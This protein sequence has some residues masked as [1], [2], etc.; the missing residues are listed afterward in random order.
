MDV[1]LL[2]IPIGIVMLY[3]G[4]EWLVKG[5][6]SLALKLR[7]AP[8]VVGLTV[9]AFGSSAPEMV[10]SIV[11]SNNPSIILGN[12]IGS[13]IANIGI[14]IGLAALICP[15]VA[16][17]DSMRI[18]IM[19]MVVMSFVMLLMMV[20]DGVTLVEGIV[21]F[22]ILFSFIFM[23]YRM[24]K[25]DEEGQK[26]YVA[27]LDEGEVR[28]KWNSYPVLIVLIIIGLALLYFGARFF[29]EGSV[30]LAIMFDVSE[31]VIGLLVVALGTSL[32]EICICLVAAKRGENE[33]AVSNIVGSNIFNICAVLG[34]GAVLT[35]I[36]YTDAVMYFHM[37]V[38]IFLSVLM[39]LIVKRKNMIS[40]RSAM[41]LLGVYV[42]YV[43]VL[44]LVPSLS[45]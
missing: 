9:V 26:S 5:A 8:F 35:T 14:A 24:K 11:S 38:M 27:E 17:Y 21:L 30:R 12:V 13:N 45:M 39:F 2:G 19:T 36:P 40:R 23:V 6:K 18:E 10:T 20:I 44:F 25:G 33:L 3:F 31:F 4:S 32:P 7:V 29:I 28:N 37:P 16:K 1:V 22:V 34:I 43:A 15:M 42:A 41:L